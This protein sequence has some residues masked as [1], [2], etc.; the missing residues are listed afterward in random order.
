MRLIILV[1]LISFHASVF[2]QTRLEGKVVDASTGTPI[3]YAN[4]FVKN[5]S[6]GTTAYRDGSFALQLDS[7][8][9]D[10]LVVSCMGFEPAKLHLPEVLSQNHLVIRLSE[11]RKELDEVEVKPREMEVLTT[12]IDPWNVPVLSLKYCQGAFGE[13]AIARH[14]TNDH[15]I[16][17]D[18]GISNAPFRLNLL[19]VD[20]LS[21]APS[22]PLVSE[23]FI[24]QADEGGIWVT[25][26]LE[27][28]LMAFP[29][30]GFFVLLQ[31][32]PL[33][34][35]QMTGYKLQHPGMSDFEVRNSAPAFGFRSEKCNKVINRFWHVYADSAWRLYK[36]P[37]VD[38][39]SHCQSPRIKADISYYA[40]QKLKIKN[41]KPKRKLRK[42]VDVPKQDFLTY[43]QS[44]PEELLQ[45]LQK[46]SEAGD[47]AYL[48]THL[49]Y[50]ETK[51]ELKNVVTGLEKLQA[52]EGSPEWEHR[53]IQSLELLRDIA[54][55]LVSLRKSDQ[56]FEYKLNV[57][58]N[59]WF[60]Y[61][62]DDLWKMG[63]E[64]ELIEGSGSGSTIKLEEAAR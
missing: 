56:R 21:G 43:P 7:L 18:K 11:A 27:K 40:D 19:Q 48:F 5:T 17:C 14:I 28:R 36:H 49:I 39:S 26:D 16:I 42:V 9:H 34:S 32:L 63:M 45:S 53:K 47:L 62:K 1:C 58:E 51:E 59:I 50:Y 31:A 6:L 4:V 13:H 2:A 61:Y 46:A 12:G 24:L 54:A 23:D 20:P 22:E 10:S 38:L 33:D 3:P 64:T 35:V 29:S 25:L 44:S 30:N 37:D 52:L 8:K 41:L 55:N 60:L 57:A 15:Q